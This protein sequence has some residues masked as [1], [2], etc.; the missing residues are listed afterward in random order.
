MI[1]LD[2]SSLAI[3]TPVSQAFWGER[4]SDVPV[5]VAAVHAHGTPAVVVCLTC[6]RSYLESSC[7]YC[8]F[9]CC[10]PTPRVPE[11]ALYS[12]LDSREE[13]SQCLPCSWR[14][15]GHSGLIDL[16][17]RPPPPKKKKCDGM[18]WYGFGKRF[19]DDSLHR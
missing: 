19:A 10:I 6:R 3:S 12:S 8:R 14:S 2:Q 9:R 5:A 1:S 4:Y 18:R 13:P 16:P 7:C 15:H 11:V 17:R